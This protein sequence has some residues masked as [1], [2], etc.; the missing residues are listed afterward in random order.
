MLV[1]LEYHLRCGTAEADRNQWY[2]FNDFLVTPVQEQKVYSAASWKV[3]A[4]ATYV[5]ED[6]DTLVDYSKLPF[7]VD[8]RFLLRD[9]TLVP[10]N[11]CHKH[12]DFLDPSELPLG[13]NYL[14]ALDAEFV[15]VREEE[16]EIRSD[17][18]R[19]LIKP[20]RSCLARVSVVRGNGPKEGLAFIDDYIANT[21]P[22]LDYLTKFS[23]IEP[24]D[25]DP[26]VSRHHVTNLKLGYYKLRAL[27]DAGC[28]FIGH[29][30]QQDFRII[31]TTRS[32]GM[33]LF[34]DNV[35]RYPRAEEASYRHGGSVPHVPPQVRSGMR[36]LGV[37]ANVWAYRKI[38]LR[39]LAW[40]LLREDIQA[41]THDS[42]EDSRTA[43]AVYR[44]Y[45]E[46]IEQGTFQ[47][48]LE[49]I[50]EYGRAHNWTIPSTSGLPSAG[51][52]RSASMNM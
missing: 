42:I 20:S 12:A 43:L 31:S 2:L 29:G 24:G 45:Q 47:S 52:S 38:G 28:V 32:R 41:E 30:L 40:Y 39:F 37:F 50:Y 11:K 25:L 1:P 13:K 27:V 34:A 26:A 35:C 48:K 15:S 4:V 3:P 51:L 33:G 5:R 49:E 21:E 6:L 36:A 16:S 44:R 10:A 8:E 22:V 23:G 17:G 9:K 18:T 19:S 7:I 14:C 46:L